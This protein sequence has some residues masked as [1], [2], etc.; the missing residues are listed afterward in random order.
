MKLKKIF[1]ILIL[2]II[3]FNIISCV[4]AADSFIKD[5][6]DKITPS[7]SAQISTVKDK[8]WGSIKL[9]LQVAAIT[10]VLACGVRYMIASA[11]QKADIKKSLAAV[12]IGSAIVFGTTLI[13]DFVTG[14]AGQ[15]MGT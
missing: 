5:S 9:I 14:A 10:A 4:L 6:S 13:I 2:F 15:L 1:C 8:A 7:G 11:D 3:V 12:I